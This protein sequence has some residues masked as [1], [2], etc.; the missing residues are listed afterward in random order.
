M[1]GVI[2][3]TMTIGVDERSA[4]RALLKNFVF[5][6]FEKRLYFAAFFIPIVINLVVLAAQT[7]FGVSLLIFS[8]LKDFLRLFLANILLTPLWEEL[9]WRG[10][11]L[12]KLSSQM[13]LGKASLIIGVVWASWHFVLYKIVFHVSTR[14]FLISFATITAM[15]VVLAILYSKTQSLILPILFHA[16]WN[17]ATNWIVTVQSTYDLYPVLLEAIAMWACAGAAWYF[18]RDIIKRYS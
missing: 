14:S 13:G 2:A 9:G 10:F 5:L 1:P 4:G 7:G 11:L 8:H 12:P 15:S 17:A 3:L 6:R 18:Y 16:S